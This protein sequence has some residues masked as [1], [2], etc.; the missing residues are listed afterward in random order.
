MLHRGNKPSGKYGGPGKLSCQVF[1]VTQQRC[2]MAIKT[3]PSVHTKCIDLRLSKTCFKAASTMG[4]QPPQLMLPLPEKIWRTNVIHNTNGLALR[5]TMHN[6]MSRRE[7]CK[8]ELE[9][10]MW[11][12]SSWI[13]WNL[14]FSYIHRTGQFTPKMK[15]NVEPCLLSSL[16]WIDSGAVVSQHCLESFFMK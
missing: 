10:Y 15:A 16:G 6:Q 2:A 13:P 7:N 5:I 12:Y 14:S 8:G 9:A 11:V 4:S 3:I 1:S